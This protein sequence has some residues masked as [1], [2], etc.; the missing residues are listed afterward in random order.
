MFKLIILSLNTLKII[1]FYL[2]FNFFVILSYLLKNI[3]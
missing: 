1:N 2:F 3:N